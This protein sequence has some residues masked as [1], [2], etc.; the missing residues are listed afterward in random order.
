[1]RRK[2]S[3]IEHMI[4]GNIVYFIRLEGAFSSENLHSALERVQH[5]HPALRVL[6]REEKD[7]LYYEA[8]C[9]P[10]IPLRIVPRGGEEDFRCECEVELKTRFDWDQ[11]QLRVVW[12]QSELEQELLL[13]TSHRICDGMSMLTIVR[14]VLRSLHS[15][16]ELMPY[17]PI[18]TKDI[19]G[20][21]E[22]PHPLTRK[23]QTGLVNTL[24]R[25]IPSTWRDGMNRE[26]Y[27]EWS[28][29]RK[30]TEALRQR[31]KSEDVSVHAALTAALDRA[32][33]A[34]LGKKKQPAWIESPM[35]ARRGRLAALK[36]DMV[37]FGGGS[38]KIRTGQAV[39]ANFWTQARAIHEQ[40]RALIEQE[41]LEIPGRYHFHEM[42]RPLSG[43]KI[44][45]MVRLADAMK[46]NGSW[47]R[48]AL[49]NLGNVILT[50]A[51]APFRLK[52]LR[53]YVHSFNIRLLGLVSYMLHGEMRFSYLGDEKCMNL[54]Q[55]EALKR[56]L[57][58]ILQANVTECGDIE[59]ENASG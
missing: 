45:T 8:D 39:E 32:L 51:D 50:D 10:A 33:L 36:S 54:S 11:P 43:A 55:A 44:H 3:S 13:T 15:R 42:L 30:L 46:I 49:S 52:D 22:P 53:I 57:T 23:L 26:I 7:G 37:F 18:T 9:A 59:V 4:D 16:E 14:E 34:V 25:L 1:M 38:F 31:C 35:D 20:D 47:N 56:E 17:A 41:L 40:I 21:Y 6:I 48:F 5:K 2:L 12:L 29:D 24:F 28:A 19:I 27:L 58:A